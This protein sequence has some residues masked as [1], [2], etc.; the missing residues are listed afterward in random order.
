MIMGHE[1]RGKYIIMKAH[2]V[3]LHYDDGTNEWRGRYIMM[4]AHSVGVHYEQANT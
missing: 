3:G 2:S 1:W 4:K